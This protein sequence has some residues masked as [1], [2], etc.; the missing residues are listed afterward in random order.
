MFR[1]YG[2]V[3]LKKIISPDGRKAAS[4]YVS[5]QRSDRFDNDTDYEV[6]V[7]DVATKQKLDSWSYSYDISHMTRHESGKPVSGVG[8]TEDS[9]HVIIKFGDGSEEREKIQKTAVV[10]KVAEVKSDDIYLTLMA[11]M[12]C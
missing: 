10:A 6:V 5:R 2:F 7:F 8:F 12:G 11:E 4:W 9:S 3:D 1:E